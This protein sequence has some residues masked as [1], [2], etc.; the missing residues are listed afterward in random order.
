MIFHLEIFIANLYR[1]K[2]M[3]VSSYYFQAVQYSVADTGFFRGG[4]P[5][6]EW[7]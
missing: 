2:N 5:T 1:A 7:R 4:A 3:D 6:L